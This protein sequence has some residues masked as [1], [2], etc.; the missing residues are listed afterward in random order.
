M[1]PE[2]LSIAIETLGDLF[3]RKNTSTDF[4]AMRTMEYYISDLD[5]LSD[6]TTV[7]VT[8]EQQGAYALVPKLRLFDNKSADE[9]EVTLSGLGYMNAEIIASNIAFE[10]WKK[11]R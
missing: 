7:A 2:I 4:L 8:I 5:L 9:I 3:F 6:T 10:E 11:R 1:K